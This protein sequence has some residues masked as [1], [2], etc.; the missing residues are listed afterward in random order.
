VSGG[1]LVFK[2]IRQISAFTR[3]F[4]TLKR[5][6]VRFRLEGF[7]PRFGGVR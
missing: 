3:T 2:K 6:R 5:L 1:Q 7:V 4:S